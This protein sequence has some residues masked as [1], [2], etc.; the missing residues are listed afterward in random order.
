VTILVFAFGVK[1]DQFPIGSAFNG[2]GFK[3]KLIPELKGKRSS[4][5]VL[6]KAFET[7]LFSMRLESHHTSSHLNF[8]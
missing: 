5:K 2:V 1:E 6:G 7:V 8:N 4:E 3:E